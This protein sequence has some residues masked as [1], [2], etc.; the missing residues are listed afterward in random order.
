MVASL[1]AAPAAKAVSDDPTTLSLH[2]GA[3]STDAL[4]DRFLEALREK[5]RDA[6]R[7]LRVSE[8]EYREIIM[9]GHVPV[10]QPFRTYTEEMSKYAWDTLNTKSGYWEIA[11]VDRFGGR[12][13]DVK[14]VT[15]IEGVDEFATYTAHR[16]LRLKLQEGDG[17]EVELA[18]GS[19]AEIDGQFKFVS[20]IRD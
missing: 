1:S 6:L 5:D 9:P 3:P 7:R 13:Y 15:F 4:I 17:A 18:T 12:A 11:L 20:Y 14:S 10:G 16:Q 2:G 19:I 8:S